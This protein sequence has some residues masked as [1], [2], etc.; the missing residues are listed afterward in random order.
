MVPYCRRSIVALLLLFLCAGPVP[1]MAQEE[2]LVY[3][4]EFLFHVLEENS[5]QTRRFTLVLREDETGKLRVLKRVRVPHLGGEKEYVET[6]LKCDAKFETK[7][8]LLIFDI[9][10][11]YSALSETDRLSSTESPVLHEWQSSLEVAVRPGSLTLVASA[12]PTPDSRGYKVE[13]LAERI[14]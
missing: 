2:G 5:Q 10:V 4:V 14:L 9:D 13:L 11:V 6:G 7:D 3:K 8:G 1:V 12:D